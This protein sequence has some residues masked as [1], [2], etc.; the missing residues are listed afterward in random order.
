MRFDPLLRSLVI[1]SF[2]VPT[3]GVSASTL[4]FLKD[5]PIGHFNEVDVKL[6]KS[7]ATTL[8]DDGDKGAAR[9]WKNTAT[10]N[11]GRIEVKASFETADG[12]KCKRLLVINRAKD[13]EGRATYPVCKAPDGSWRLDESA[14]PGGQS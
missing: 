4:S 8:L 2:I 1:L 3:G 12:R 6:M 10:G 7:A 5:S 9:E 14:E 11:S 13:V